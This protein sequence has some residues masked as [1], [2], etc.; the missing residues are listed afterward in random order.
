MN[1][2][3]NQKSS[4]DHNFHCHPCENRDPEIVC[5]NSKSL[6]TVHENNKRLHKKN[7]NNKKTVAIIGGGFSGLV[8]GYY[9]SQK[10]YKVVIFEKEKILGGFLKT[11][12][13]KNISYEEY[14]HHFFLN[15][16]QLLSLINKL[17]LNSKIIWRKS[18][19][20]NYV[21]KSFFPI[22][23][24]WDW[25]FFPKINLFDK[26]KSFSSSPSLKS[27]NPQKIHTLDSYSFIRSYLGNSFF[28]N[29]WQTLFEKKFYSKGKNISAA[30]FLARLQKR[31]NSRKKGFETLGYL[32]GSFTL[33]IDKLKLSIE[34]NNGKIYLNTPVKAIK[35]M[36]TSYIV[37][38]EKF[39]SVISTVSNPKNIFSNVLPKND[40]KKYNQIS[41]NGVV[42]VAIFSKKQLSKFYWTNILD[43]DIPFV[44]FVEHTNTFDLYK[45]D[46]HLSYLGWYV[47]EEKLR[48]LNN[49]KIAKITMLTI[50]KMFKNTNDIIKI[51]IARSKHAQPIILK[52]IKIPSFVTSEKNIIITNSSHIF[53]DDRGLNEAA[54]EAMKISRLFK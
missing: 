11:K 14:Y 38:N 2:K 46:F 8:I 43:K 22:N 3:T 23:S 18:S 41:S 34:N 29:F 40:L 36:E 6:V 13:Y 24:L 50:Q 37:N 42:C 27:I 49:K 52:N 10:K 51:N 33:L 4:T 35:K 47:E 31:I 15:D 39:D 5:I 48:K 17:R 32:D 26:L 9:L 30:W 53:P 20:A 28:E 7:I 45:K 54:I 21:N 1:Q 44:S 19:S 25:L 12:K 16:A